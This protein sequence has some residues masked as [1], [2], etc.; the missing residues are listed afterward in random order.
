M[1]R[2]HCIGSNN[3]TATSLLKQDYKE[4]IGI[5]EALEL[6]VKVLSKT[7]DST[8]L[9]H[10][11]GKSALHRCRL[12]SVSNTITLLNVVEIATITYNEETNMTIGHILTHKE[13]DTLLEKC[14]VSKKPEEAVTGQ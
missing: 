9:D 5:E 3:A 11:K 7:M 13:L 14:G 2:A 1:I 12:A 8:T 4:D 6:A 10:E